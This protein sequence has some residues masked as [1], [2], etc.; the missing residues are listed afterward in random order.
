VRLQLDDA[1][2]ARQGFGQMADLAGLLIG[3]LSRAGIKGDLREKMVLAW[4]STMI[5][6]AMT[7]N[8]VDVFKQL[9]GGED[10]A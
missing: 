8:L 7:P 2:E 6:A 1:Q 10:D 4:W 9:T 3:E 5:N